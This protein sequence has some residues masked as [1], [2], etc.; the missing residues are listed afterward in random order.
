MRTRQAL[1]ISAVGNIYLISMEIFWACQTSKKVLP[2]YVKLLPRLSSHREDL[3]MHAR[4]NKFEGMLTGKSSKLLVELEI[5]RDSRSRCSWLRRLGLSPRS[6]RWGATYL[7]QVRSHLPDKRQCKALK[8]CLSPLQI[9]NDYSGFL[10]QKEESIPRGQPERESLQ[11]SKEEMW[12][13][14]YIGG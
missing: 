3:V 6:P 14:G 9:T 2:G 10:D 4:I 5:Q 12:V 8:L 11:G 13:C 7:W 1:W